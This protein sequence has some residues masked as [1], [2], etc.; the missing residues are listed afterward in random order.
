MSTIIKGS[1]EFEIYEEVGKK[2][3]K[4]YTAIKLKFKDYELPNIYFINKDQI[5]IIKSK[6][7][8]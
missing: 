8:N 1:A 2:S 7:E 3:G 6:L 5:Y 4:P